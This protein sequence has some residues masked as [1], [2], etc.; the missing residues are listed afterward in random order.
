MPVETIK[1]NE[2][3]SV[4]VTE[5]KAGSYVC[6]HC[7]AVFKHVD[8]SGTASCSCGTFA[9]GRCAECQ[10]PVCVDCSKR[11]DGRRLCTRHATAAIAEATKQRRAA[12]HQAE[13]QRAAAASQ[14]LAEEKQR[15]QRI[16]DPF[17]RLCVA[18]Q[19][20][21]HIYVQGITH[22]RSSLSG[23]LLTEICPELWPSPPAESD[24]Q[25]EPPWNGDDVARWFARRAQKDKIPPDGTASSERWGHTLFGKPKKITIYSGPCWWFREGSTLVTGV[26]PPTRQSACV[27]ANGELHHDIRFQHHENLIPDALVSMAERLGHRVGST[28]R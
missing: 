1:C 22:V 17:E 26:E 19:R 20:L 21:T 23:T 15:L 12:E 4:E 27:L 24:W 5:F 3:G 10:M 28:D 25:T 9:V 16:A 11:V 6:S 2:C 14:K 8:P 13:L 18:L 7:E